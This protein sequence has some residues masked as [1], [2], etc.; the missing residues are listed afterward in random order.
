VLAL[1]RRLAAGLEG[2]CPALLELGETFTDRVLDD[3]DD[4]SG[5]PE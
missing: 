5:S 4:G 3:A 2:L 1:D